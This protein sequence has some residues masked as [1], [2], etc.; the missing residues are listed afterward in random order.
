VALP[1]AG[2]IDSRGSAH[3]ACDGGGLAE[4]AACWERLKDKRSGNVTLHDFR[5]LLMIALCTVLSG[6]QRA[7]EM[8]T[9]AKAKEPFLRGFRKLANGSPS[10]ETFSG[11]FGCSIRYVSALPFG[12]PARNFPGYPGHLGKRWEGSAPFVRSRQ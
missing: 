7:P 10:H 12:G 2:V 8:A 6:G 11:L 5:E 4:L 9:L 1:G 3:A